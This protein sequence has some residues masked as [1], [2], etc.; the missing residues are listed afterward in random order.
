[1][2][3]VVID[4]NVMVSA[5]LKAEGLEAKVVRWALNRQAQLYVSGTILAEY[6]RVRRYP[7][8][9]FVPEEI[10]DFLVRVRRN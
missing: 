6:E 4:T 2:I 3:G 7:A 1:M 9:K 10:D 8:F 5:N